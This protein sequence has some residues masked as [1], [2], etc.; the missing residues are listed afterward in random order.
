MVNIKLYDTTLRDGTQYEGISLSVEDKL[1]VT[2]NLDELG[3]HF[4]EGGWPGANRKDAEYFSKA[5]DLKL[6]HSTLAAFGSTRKAR[7][8]PEQ[9]PNLNALLEAGTSVITLVGKTWDLHVTRVLE[10]NLEENLSMISD[11]IAFLKRKGKRVFF[12]A[13]HFFDGFK[14][15]QSYAM[16]CVKAA[17][18]AGAECVILCDTNGGT[19]PNEVTGIVTKARSE[20]LV[21][22]GIHAHNDA[23]VAVANTLA[24]V[25]AGATQVQGTANG[26]GERCGNAN[27]FSIIANLK[28]KLGINCVTDQQLAK[29]TEA[30]YSI[31]EIANMPTNAFQPYVGSSAFTHKG[32][33]HASAVAK[34]EES[35]QH[36]APQLIGNKN[37]I[38]ISELA[39]RA[40]ITH[41]LK[42]LGLDMSVSA[43]G[44]RALLNE[45][46]ERES[47]GFQ[48]EDAEASFE[49]L[50]R[51]TIDG[52]LPPFELVDFKVMAE[53]RHRPSEPLEHEYIQSEA[54][55]K[56]RVTGE[57]MHTAAEGNGPVNA[58]DNALRKAL[59]RFYP[60]L[61]IVRL[62]DYKVR[63]VDQGAGT[64]AMVRVVIESTDGEHRWRTVGSSGNIIDASWM[65]LADSFE[66]WLT[67][68]A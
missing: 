7:I 48:Y 56:V 27:I 12:D 61:E 39:G 17:A 18:N 66:Y 45:V 37:H 36:V 50:V 9:D 52:Y 24:A 23:E 62:A 38:L 31:S 54:T 63:V 30:H 2:S 16:E 20:T 14:A 42:E 41:K 4:I 34:V 33:L 53:Q 60:S 22:L 1:K 47:R 21:E 40:N 68:W 55:V 11:S 59:L 28:L 32:G 25:Q 49:L 43:D 8:T 64:E 67:K 6:N 19:L 65:A 46:K 15:N 10:T 26:Y 3:M 57:V 5:K 13:E 51:R 58:L 44:T 35:Y 29:L